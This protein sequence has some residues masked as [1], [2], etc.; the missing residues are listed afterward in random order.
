MKTLQTLIPFMLLMLSCSG[1]SSQTDQIS[2]S[3][4]PFATG[5]N[6]PVCIS[7]CNDSRLFITEQPGYVRIVDTAGNVSAQPYL[8]IHDRVQFG[9]EQG[10][11]G[12]AF[13]PSYSENGYLYVNYT[14]AGDS[15]HI[16]RFTVSS[17]D[18]NLADPQSELKIMT[19]YQPYSNH[20]G[21]DLHFGP[22]G[23]LYIGLGDGGSGGD[24]G[25]RA[26]NRNEY[27]GKIL[28]IDVNQGSPYSIPSSNPFYNSPDA[29]G[30]IW[31][32]GLRNPWRFSFDRMTGDMWIADV[33][34]NA[35]EEINFQAASSAGG[36]NYGWRCYEGNDVYNNAGCGDD[37]TFPVHTYSHDDGCS[38]TG[39]IVYRGDNSSPFYGHYFYTD[40]CTDMIWTLHQTGLSWVN[41]DFGQFPGNNFSAFGDDNLGKL[42]IAGLTSG[43]IFRIE[44]ASST[45]MPDGISDEEIKIQHF[46]SSRK[47]R[48]E[49]GLSNKSEVIYK[50]VSLNGVICD[51]GVS[52]VPDFEI[53]TDKLAAG[54]YYLQIIVGNK[55]KGTKLII[56]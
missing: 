42:Y 15:T 56:P 47:L 55:S 13:H 3:L 37:F 17:G 11:L 33:G 30:E 44:T 26:Q 49:T 39:G 53:S 1:T 46:P 18:P 38:V 23:Y 52:K 6:N 25:N 7:H 20:N 35:I 45:G 27:L 24:P 51:F 36:E 14:G 32:Y 43:T 10:L 22:D 16:S 41:M 40:Y 29:L 28:R 21:G 4:I 19:L 54:M 34:Q 50:M 12:L 31:A 8:D 9:G 5:F 2:N 48:V